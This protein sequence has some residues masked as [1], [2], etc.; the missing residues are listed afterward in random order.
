[1]T[2]HFK[3]RKIDFDDLKYT[4]DLYK[5]PVKFKLTFQESKNDAD[6]ISEL[7]R[8]FNDIR[9]KNIPEFN[10]KNKGEKDIFAAYEEVKNG[11]FEVRL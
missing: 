6:I 9:R 5:G 1:M 3:G 11:I 4:I 2:I 7:D 8:I 10:A